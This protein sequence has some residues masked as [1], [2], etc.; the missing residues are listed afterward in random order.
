MGAEGAIRPISLTPDAAVVP[1]PGPSVVQN[2]GCRKYL[3]LAVPDIIIMGHRRGALG[4]EG[5]LR[6][7]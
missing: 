5:R 4:E 6:S 3:R 1:D 7:R 2:P